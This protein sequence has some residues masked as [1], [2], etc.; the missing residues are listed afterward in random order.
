MGAGNHCAVP[1]CNRLDFL[2]YPCDA[3]K[4]IYCE[5]HRGYAIHECR[6]GYTRDRIVPSCPICNKLVPS[7]PGQTVDQAMNRHINDGCA[8]VNQKGRTYKNKCSH[9][10]CKKREL[11]EM[12]CKTCRLNF[13]MSHRF[14]DDHNCAGR[15][16]AAAT[17]ASKRRQPESTT[18]AP[19]QPKR[20]TAAPAMA[21]RFS[22]AAGRRQQNQP[23]ISR[24]GAP[25]ASA[26][27]RQIQAVPAT[28]SEEEAL[29]AAIA[30]S[31]AD[32]GNADRTFEPPKTTP[33]PS[34]AVN[35]PQQ[36][37]TGADADL[38]LALAMSASMAEEEAKA[39]AKDDDKDKAGLF[40]R[41]FGK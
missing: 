25:R 31:L 13:C 22:P 35:A 37:Q 23:P 11:V 40:S 19:A 5:T 16:S 4:N 21:K 6:E 33:K 26:A 15:A 24:F 3:C 7:K 12:H 41:W 10:K 17:A 8:S 27:P 29:A 9:L 28:M 39:K 14:E 20:V 30:A 2:P 38:E 36:P 1:T 18:S 32:D 34:R